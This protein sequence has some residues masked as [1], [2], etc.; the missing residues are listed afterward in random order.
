MSIDT[1]I[2]VLGH[3]YLLCLYGIILW[4]LEQQLTNKITLK[5]RVAFVGRSMIWA[6]AIVVF[7]DE[8]ISVINEKIDFVI[9]E[10]WYF[11]LIAGFLIDIVRSVVTSKTK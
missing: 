10:E 7:D 2:L 8:I 9:H 3:P 1:V 6:G 11:Y 4:Q 5:N